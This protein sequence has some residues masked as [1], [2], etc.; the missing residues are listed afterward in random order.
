[1]L[2][3]KLIRE[4]S[5]K[6]L[7]SREA[8]GYDL[9]ADAPGHLSSGETTFVPCGFS[10]DL[11]AQYTAGH[12]RGDPELPY[13]GSIPLQICALILPRSGLGCRYGITPANSPGL[14]DPDYR[15]EISVCLTNNGPDFFTWQIGDRIA[16]M[17]LLP[18]FTDILEVVSELTPTVRASSG[19]GSTG[20]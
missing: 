17:L 20:V 7:R 9:F 3:I 5:C 19:F 16:Q 15:G 10:I 6:P 13:Q 11:S 18:Y 2:K 14:I 12:Y 1:M 4:T 8:A